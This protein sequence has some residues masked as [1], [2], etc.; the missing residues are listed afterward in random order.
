MS[1]QINKK[2]IA[3]IGVSGVFPKSKNIEELWSNILDAKELIHFYTDEELE[4]LGIDRAEHT[5]TVFADSLISDSDTF[6]NSFFGFNSEEAFFMDPQIR[7]FFEHS[8]S[9]IEDAGY[10]ITTLEERIGVFAS[11]SDNLNW[12]AFTNFIKSKNVNPFYLQQISNKNYINS[13]LSYKLNLRGPSYCIN[14]ACSSS[15]VAVHIACRN[16]LLRECSMA[17]AGASRIT[18]TKEIGYPY[19]QGMIFSKDGHCKAFDTDSS[20]TISGEGVAVVVLKRLEDAVKDRDNIYAV[21]KSSSTNND[22]A[23]KIGFTAPSVEGQYDCIKQAQKVAKIDPATISFVEAHGTGTELGDSIEIES[24]N[25]A[26][27]FNNQKHCAIG[28]IKTNIGHLDSASG[29]TGLVKATMTIKNRMLP[30]SLHFQSP[31][32]NINFDQGPFYVNDKNIHFDTDKVLRG[33][34]SSFGMGGTNAH[35]I[36]EESPVQHFSKKRKAYELIAFSSKTENALNRYETKIID[37]LDKNRDSSL[38]DASYTFLTG[39][40]QFDC[41]SFMVVKDNKVAVQKRNTLSKTTN[42]NL[43]FLFSGQGSQ[44]YKMG[45]YLYTEEPYFKSIMDMGFDIIEKETGKDFKTFLYNDKNKDHLEINNTKYTQPLLFL[46]DYALAKTLVY[47]GV[48]PSVMMGHSLGEYV[49]ACISGVFKFDE[50]LHLIIKRGELMSSVHSGAMLAINAS[51]ESVK[52]ELN[53]QIDIAVINTPNSFVISGPENEILNIQ[54]NLKKKEIGS[55]LLPTSHGFHS[56]AMDS[57]LDSF[58]NEVSQIEMQEPKIPFVSNVTG[59]VISNEMATSKE[60]WVSHLRNTVLFS[61][62]IDTLLQVENSTFIEIGPGTSLINMVK[63][64]SKTANIAVAAFNTIKRSKERDNQDKLILE[65]LGNLWLKGVAVDWNA[66][67]EGKENHRV[68]V[69]TYPFEG[70]VFPCRVDPLEKHNVTIE[71]S[72]QEEF[73]ASIELPTT[74][75]EILHECVAPTTPIEEQLVEIWRDFFK[76]DNVGVTDNF[77]ELGGDSLRAVV[78]MNR[79]NDE[80]GVVLSIENLYDTLSIKELAELLN[81]SILQS[82]E[83]TISQDNDEVVI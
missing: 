71:N 55:V 76:L 35:V 46:L 80:F 13:L 63:Q 54:K 12:R 73:S 43:I 4:A 7:K 83:S 68:S 56:R 49:A 79:I 25:K 66:Y 24:L 1:T 40:A 65:L 19:E 22:G 58:E 72:E 18:S 26:F 50:A 82:Q 67:F 45:E 38:S 48:Q 52:E 36:L 39:R 42:N 23:N 30:A 6:D 77:F 10:D 17:I 32:P 16:L 14:T 59:K 60:Y 27:E 3:I 5:N 64:Q 69:P 61:K 57:I 29:V 2:D 53:D 41:R 78:L 21:I 75:R 47:W 20:G 62:G 34:V 44:Y 9:A 11:A 15:L 28:S 70:T 37:F 31:N 33:A 74:Q 8:W 81:F 51:L